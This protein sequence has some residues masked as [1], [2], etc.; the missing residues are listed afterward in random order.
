MTGYNVKLGKAVVN[1]GARNQVSVSFSTCEAEYFSMKISCQEVIWINRV[2]IEIGLPA[3]SPT[4]IR[5]DNQSGISWEERQKLPS[6]LAK[7]IDVRFHYI[8]DGITQ[9]LVVIRYVP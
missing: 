1:W 4:T 2:L 6:K 8:H 7:H 5:S 9:H 3:K